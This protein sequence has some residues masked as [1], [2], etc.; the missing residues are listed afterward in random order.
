MQEPSLATDLTA[1]DARP[2]PFSGITPTRG[3]VGAVRASIPASRV[4][5]QNAWARSGGWEYWFPRFQR[6]NNTEQEAPLIILG[7]G[8]EFSGGTYEVGESDDSTVNKKISKAMRAFLP[9]YFPGMFNESDAEHKWEMEWVM[10]FFFLVC[11]G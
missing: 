2:A 6:L 4:R 1:K 7:G 8:R 5:W 11:E 10:I 9:N 3:Q